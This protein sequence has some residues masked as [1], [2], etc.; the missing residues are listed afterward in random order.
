MGRV[1]SIAAVFALIP[2]LSAIGVGAAAPPRV[3][4]RMY[5]ADDVSG[6][7]F[8]KDPAVVRFHSKYWLYYSVPP[9][10]GKSTTGWSIGVATSNNLVD[11]TKAA[12]C[13]TRVKLRRRALRL[14]APLC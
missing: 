9:Y 5:F 1:R 4:P 8:S 12:N 2:V 13:R 3:T 6:K 7:P 14:R 10:E 11:W